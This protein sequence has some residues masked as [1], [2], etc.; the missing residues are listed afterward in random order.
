MRF[1]SLVETFRKSKETRVRRRQ[2]ASD[3]A[4]LAP[5]SPGY[6]R[7]RFAPRPSGRFTTASARQLTP[8][9]EA[10]IAWRIKGGMLEV[11]VRGRWVRRRSWISSGP[12]TRRWAAACVPARW[13]SRAEWGESSPSNADSSGACVCEQCGFFR[14]AATGP[15]TA[16][17]NSDA[18]VSRA[19]PCPTRSSL[20]RP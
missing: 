3:R 13:R 16:Y 19:R 7:I 14:K 9:G 1:P 5:A 10:A 12:A 11:E 6:Q 2:G 20:A 8:Y 18:Q 17:R 15:S 4:P